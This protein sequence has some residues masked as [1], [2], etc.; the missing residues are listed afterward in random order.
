MLD[1]SVD[2]VMVTGWM[3]QVQAE[4]PG[5]RDRTGRCCAFG[6]TLSGW[7]AANHRGTREQSQVFTEADQKDR[8]EVYLGL[9]IRITYRPYRRLVFATVRPLGGE[10]QSVSE[11][12]L[13]PS[14]LGRSPVHLIV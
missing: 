9:G 14:S 12:G 1:S 7:S 10:Q 5:G 3:S 6:A 8:A 13:Q 2:L 4:R 11:G